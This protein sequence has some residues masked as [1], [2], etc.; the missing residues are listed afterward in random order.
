M[1]CMTRSSCFVGTPLSAKSAGVRAARLARATV[2]VKAEKGD[3]DLFKLAGGRG[4]G[5]GEVHLLLCPGA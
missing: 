2:Q 3:F 5:A 4:I 1:A